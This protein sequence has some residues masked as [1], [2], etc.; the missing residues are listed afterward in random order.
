MKWINY[1][2]SDTPPAFY[3]G[4][5]VRVEYTDGRQ[6]EGLNP[7]EFAGWNHVSPNWPGN[8]VKYAIVKIAPARKKEQKV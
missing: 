8:I 7:W 3:P 4:E 6:A 5:K 1:T 2:D